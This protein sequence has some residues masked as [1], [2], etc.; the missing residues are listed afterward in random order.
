MQ[1][2]L[3]SRI[4]AHQNS[5]FDYLKIERNASEFT[6]TSYKTDLD[7]FFEFF[8]QNN[9]RNIDRKTLRSFLS[10]LVG[11][12]LKPATI[13]RK[14]A[15]LRSFFKFLNSRKIINI[16][17]AE[18]LFFLK[19]EQKLP[20]FFSYETIMKAIN[21][22]DISQFEGLR[23]SLIIDMFYSTGMRLRELVNLDV[24]DFDLY[25]GVIRVIG[26]GAKERL[27]PI[28]QNLSKVT[29]MYLNER[30]DY[31]P[32]YSSEDDAFFISKKFKR[33]K[34]WQ[35]QYCVKKYLVMAGD[36]QSAYPHKLRHSFATHLLD[37]G[38]DL[39]AVKELL[40][41]SSLSTTQIYT[42]VT[43]EKLKRIYKQAHPRAEKSNL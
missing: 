31:F 12:Q 11:R 14:L 17:P 6:L 42:H 25:S 3:V 40:G 16:N 41:H 7:N 23:D 15:C 10:N 28:G 22:P 34:P 32:S 5:F 8:Q 1:Q 36:E 2:L 13:N 43:P 29:K 24:N 4:Q 20:T 26:K 18:T 21:L 38:A 33:M 30:N 27:V 37:E 19:K 9:Y 35:V 39:M